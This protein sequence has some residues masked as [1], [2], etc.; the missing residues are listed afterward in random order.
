MVGHEAA[1]CTAVPFIIIDSQSRFQ[2]AQHCQRRA[3]GLRPLLWIQIKTA[4]GQALYFKK[5]CRFCLADYCVTHAPGRDVID[6][7]SDMFQFCHVMGKVRLSRAAVQSELAAWHVG[8]ADPEGVPA[9]GLEQQQPPSVDVSGRGHMTTEEHFRSQSQITA[10]EPQIDESPEHGVAAVSRNSLCIGVAR[11][12]IHGAP[13]VH[14][15]RLSCRGAAQH[16]IGCCQIA[17]NDVLAVQVD[18]GI[19]RL[20]AHPVACRPGQLLMA[21]AVEQSDLQP[22]HQYQHSLPARD[23]CHPGTR[24]Y[25]G[26]VQTV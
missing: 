17:M 11:A 10:L 7:A 26:V 14:N 18:K 23:P 22:W 25:V 16:D 13:K 8:P 12:F 6:A 4:S 9:Q 1:L 19:T 15:D 3:H 5:C 2:A 24:Y 21:H 20:P